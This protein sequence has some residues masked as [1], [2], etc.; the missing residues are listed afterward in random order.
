MIF[1]NYKSYFGKTKTKEE[2]EEE[3]IVTGPDTNAKFDFSKY[4]W[5]L[6]V[7]KICNKLNYKPEEVYTLN[8]INCLNWLSMW[9]QY[10]KYE[11]DQMEN[12]NN[13]KRF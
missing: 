7:E 13:K 8:Y 2:L 6:M 5:L 1:Y 10:Q 4:Q 3:E 11:R 12:K 9:D